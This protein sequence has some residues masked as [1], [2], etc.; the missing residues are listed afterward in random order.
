MT[1]YAPCPYKVHRP[2]DWRKKP[3]GSPV[4]CGI[5]HPPALPED[6]IVRRPGKSEAIP[7]VTQPVQKD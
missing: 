3:K 7:S 4:V 1:K 6:Q 2:S 5:C